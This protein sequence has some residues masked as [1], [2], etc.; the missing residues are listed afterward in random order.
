MKVFYDR[1][2]T[3]KSAA[4]PKPKPDINFGL[5]LRRWRAI[6]RVSQLELALEAEISMRHLSC[7]ETGRAQPSREMV[8]QL[9]DALQVPLRERNLL[10][11]AAGYAPLYR[12]TALN[13]AD[14]CRA[15]RCGPA[16]ST[17]G[18]IPR[19]CRGPVLEHTANERGDGAFSCAIPGLH[20]PDPSQRNATRISPARTET[21]Y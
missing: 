21:V 15:L 16:V 4:R 13:S 18:A 3:S 1:N 19:N 17:T 14:G 6:R 20:F 5:L 11:S 10:L 2:V 12:Q 7:V 9:A 8:V